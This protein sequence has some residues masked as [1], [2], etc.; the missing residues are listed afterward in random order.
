MKSA[1]TLKVWTV[2]PRARSAAVRPRLIEVFPEPEPKPPTTSRGIP[3]SSSMRCLRML[4]LQALA[5]SPVARGVRRACA[6]DA[7]TGRRPEQVRSCNDARLRRGRGWMRSSP[8]WRGASKAPGGAV[9]LGFGGPNICS[10][11]QECVWRQPK[12]P[13]SRP[14]SGRS[15]ASSS[16][17]RSSCPPLSSGTSWSGF[18]M[19]SMSSSSGLRPARRP[20]RRPTSTTRRAR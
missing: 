8:L 5:L 6:L 9:S 1:P 11:L 14:W 15:S 13:P 7:S 18:G 3:T 4:A 10:I 20:S 17:P 2:R 16:C 19:A 12:P